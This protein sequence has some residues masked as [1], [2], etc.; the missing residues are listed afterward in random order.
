ML[1]SRYIINLVLFFCSQVVAHISTEHYIPPIGGT[2]PGIEKYVLVITALEEEPFEVSINN[3]DG[4]YSSV[5]SVSKSQPV[6]LT[7]MVNGVIKGFPQSQ[8]YNKIKPDEAFF[9]KAEKP[10]FANLM[11]AVKWQADILTS[12]GVSGLGQEFYTAHMHTSYI[13][14]IA[15]IKSHFISVMATEDNTLVEFENNVVKFAGH[16]SHKF[17]VT[18]NQGESY[19]I[20]SNINHLKNQCGT[21]RNCINAYNGTKISSNK[22]IAVNAGSMHGGHVMP[23]AIRWDEGR[24]IGIDQVTP[25]EFAGKNFVLMEG[26]GGANN[27]NNEVAIVVATQPG[28]ILNLNGSNSSA[29]TIRIN[30]NLGWT[31][32]PRTKYSSGNMYIESNNDV[33]VYQT[34]AGG[35]SSQ[36]PG[37]MFVPR[38]TV[39]A[40]KEVSI[41]GVNR[42]GSPSLYLVTERGS[43]TWINDV[44]LD[45]N[46]A[47]DIAGLATWVTYRIFNLDAYGGKDSDFH[48]ESTGILYA[49]ATLL[50]SAAGGGGY[51][52]GFSKDISRSGIENFGLRNLSLRCNRS[53]DLK[54]KGALSYIWSAEN[55]EHLEYLVD[56]DDSTKTF[57]ATDEMENGRYKYQV[58]SEIR[59]LQGRQMDTTILAINIDRYE[60]LGGPYRTCSDGNVVINTDVDPDLNAYYTWAQSPY[61]DDV[62][63]ASPLFTGQESLQDQSVE[64]SVS[65]D[66]GFCQFDE[67][68]EVF[69]EDCDRAKVQKAWIFDKDSNGIGETVVVKFDKVFI[70]FENI[71][72]IDWDTEGKNNYSGRTSIASYDTLA[73]GNTDSTRVILDMTDKFQF[74]T[75][76]NADSIPYLNYYLDSVE[77][78]DRIGPTVAEAKKIYP[79]TNQYAIQQKDGMLEYYDNPILIEVNLSEFISFDEDADVNDLFIFLDSRGDQVD[80]VYTEMPYLGEDSL[81]WVVTIATE[82]ADK[83][84]LV[85]DTRLNP[86]IAIEDPL[87]NESIH[88]LAA[89]VD[90]S[91]VEY[92]GLNS[93]FRTTVIGA[94]EPNEVGFVGEDVVVYDL[95]GNVIDTIA[96]EMK[97]KPKWIAPYNYQNGRWVKDAPCEDNQTI[98]VFDY[99]C[100]SSLAIGAFTG[101]GPYQVRVHVFDH[102]GQF[103]MTWKQQF[104]YCGEFENPDRVQLSGNER[105]MINDLIWDMRDSNRRKVAAGIYIWKINLTFENGESQEVIKKMGLMRSYDDCQG[106]ST[107]PVGSNTSS[108]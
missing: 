46:T 29:N 60:G 73:N 28:T 89:V 90:D 98:E 68:I 9:L 79:E 48:I 65:F 18:L 85:K 70:D 10:F 71:K 51:Y 52:S 22:D 80:F 61:L 5:V 105:L 17:S 7:P 47:A 81:T 107:R 93:E 27:A 94:M 84:P 54:A 92:I 49:A 101:K 103:V 37:M 87:G 97:L 8:V 86:L 59:T 44:L 26:R 96:Q 50:N 3:G 4:S 77:I 100:L 106:L 36:N 67:Q 19:I 63:L 14:T 99:Q 58:I 38:L 83:L 102:L 64:L 33:F 74:G 2:V 40:T 42:L 23:N 21:G 78:L 1:M 11:V 39:D 75:R 45:T 72:S 95:A 13:S 34:M 12:K 56:K 104:G 53:V 62:T 43:D 88:S 108:P 41:S 15:N 69:I 76:A 35:T 30:D 25:V 32:V 6:E 57:V 91:P 20:G 16:S 82:S 24:D 66:D 55:P 31:V